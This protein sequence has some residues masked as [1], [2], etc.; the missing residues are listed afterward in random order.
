MAEILRNVELVLWNLPDGEETDKPHVDTVRAALVD[1]RL[2]ATRATDVPP[3]TAFRRALDVI[4]DKQTLVRPFERAR[5][6]SEEKQLCAQVDRE[7]QDSEG[8]SRRRIGV[9][10]LGSD[11][12]VGTNDDCL[13]T[14]DRLQEGFRQ[15]SVTYT[16]ADVSKVIQTILTKD[17]LGAYSP[18]K[19]GG[20]YFAP[21]NP[22]AI[23]LLDRIERFATALGVRFLRYQVPDTDAQRAEIADAISAGVMADLSAHADAIG[24]YSTD[25]RQGIV[26]NRRERLEATATLIDRLRPL[27]GDR[28]M[29]LTNC[30][31]GLRASLQA[32][33][34]AAAERTRPVSGRR[35]VSQ[36][37]A[38]Q[39]GVAQ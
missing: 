19:A 36:P 35:I 5:P 27:L 32:A 16:W 20:V 18:R 3:G 29:A 10:A 13:E 38:Q 31:A 15:T 7:S 17:G 1:T 11:G 26:E 37:I 4:R 22:N 14:L 34:T 6:G 12:P 33:I 28:A 23:D 25:T 24:G 9:Y 21:V 2:P 30:L 39:V 8:L